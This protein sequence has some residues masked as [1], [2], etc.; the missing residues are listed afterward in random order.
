MIDIVSFLKLHVDK[1]QNKFLV[2][3]YIPKGSLLDELHYKQGKLTASQKLKMTLDIAKV[4]SFFHLHTDTLQGME[5]LEDSK[6]V[7]SKHSITLLN[8]FTRCR[9]LECKKLSCEQS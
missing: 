7:H 6:I 5:Y 8:L 1:D 4:C 2:F 3:E 9:R